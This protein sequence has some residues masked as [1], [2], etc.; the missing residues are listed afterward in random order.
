MRKHSHLPA[1]TACLIAIFIAGA[2]THFAQQ[3]NAP[4]GQRPQ[5][6]AAQQQALAATFKPPETIDYRRVNIL[7]EGVRMHGELFSL[8]SLAGKKLPV[9]I[10][11]HG[12]GGTAAA[13]RTDSIDLA[14]AGY[15]VLAFDYRGW[16]E[17]DSRLILTG[18]SPVKPVS[19]Q[20][21]KF[22]AEVTEVR[23]A[24]DPLE[25]VTD[26]FN[27]IHWIM[28]EP[29]ADTARIGLR[30]SS[31]SGGHVVYVAARDPRVRAI[32][33]QVSAFD[34]RPAAMTTLGG[35]VESQIKLASSVIP[36]HGSAS[37]GLSSAARFATNS[38]STTRWRMPR[39]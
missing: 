29:M 22:S 19:G 13:F 3:A 37:S 7:S 34:S 39:S 2:S 31:Y 30:G 36:R 12:W 33:G 5:D 14:N 10:Q 18:A 11:A 6:P 8:Q 24:V 35:S 25:F 21:Q 27:A 9:V 23:E 28:A 4:A 20:N 32:V 16:G 1:I 17:S 15:L 38:C 26:W